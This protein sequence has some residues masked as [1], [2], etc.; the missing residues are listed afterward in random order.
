MTPL[1]IAMIGTLLIVCVSA[2][3][4]GRRAER[5]V[6]TVLAATFAVNAAP[7]VWALTRGEQ[8]PYYSEPTNLAIDLVLLAVLVGV[9]VSCRPGWTLFA[10][11]FQLLATLVSFVNLTDE[12]LSPRAYYTAQNSLWWL[13][14][15][16]LAYGVWVRN[17]SGASGGGAR[18]AAAAPSGPSLG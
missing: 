3:I 7:A 9:G 5:I 17:R 2:L 1:D 18:E 14:I 12:G 13:T 6:A 16:A 10:A 11:A 15:G 8:R 4:R